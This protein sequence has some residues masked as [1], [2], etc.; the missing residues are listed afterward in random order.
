[1]RKG[2]V[3]TLCLHLSGGKKLLG[4]SKATPLLTC[5]KVSAAGGGGCVSSRAWV[6]DDGA[7]QHRTSRALIFGRARLVGR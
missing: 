7:A 6:R 2:I 1:M 3:S 4:L 5:W